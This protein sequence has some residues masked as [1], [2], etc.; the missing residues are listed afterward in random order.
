[1]V[2]LRQRLLDNTVDMTMLRRLKKTLI[3]EFPKSYFNRP[4]RPVRLGS[5][6]SPT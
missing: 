5:R 6:A 3:C 4:I 1:M 2:Q